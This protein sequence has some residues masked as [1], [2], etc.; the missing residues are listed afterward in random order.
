MHLPFPGRHSVPWF[1]LA[2]RA[3]Q[4]AAR[5]SLLLLALAVLGAA[6]PPGTRGKARPA[7]PARGTLPDSVLLRID[8][9]ED[10]T[11]RRFE[12]AVRLLGGDPDSLTPADRDQFLDMVIEQRLLAARAR[13]DPHPWSPLDSV[14]YRSELD[15]ILLRAALSDRFDDVE[16]RRRAR[17]QPDLDEEAMG[18][19]ARES[20]MVDV[21]PEWDEDLLRLVGSYFAELPK[22]TAEMTI[23]EQ[24]ELANLVPRIPPAETLKVLVRSTLGPLTVADVVGDWR[25]LSSLYRPQVRDAEAVRALAENGIFERWIRRAS[26]DPSL[27]T[28]PV[29]AAVIADRAE[30]HSVSSLLRRELLESIPR[31]S[32]T[33]ERHYRT[34]RS[35]FDLPA[36]ASLVILTLGTERAA[37]SLA[38]LFA[39]PGE[40][41]SLAFRA[42]RSGVRYTLRVTE[43]SDSALYRLATRTGAGGVG[44]PERVEGGWR[45]FKVLALDPRRPQAFAAVR[46]DVERSW[47]EAESERRIRAY[48]DRLKREAKFQRNEAAL[49]ALVRRP[50]GR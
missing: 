45:V 42:Q 44:G 22:P 17:G 24:M 12:R 34:N 48:L 20:L 8:G 16:R 19:A 40:A 25:R 3:L 15:H 2:R 13:R 1:R 37:D 10:I 36:S 43:A 47:N 26:S 11:R 33:L 39:V 5:A 23:R 7:G 41:E 6:A 32:A 28:R 18:M 49:R 27:P 30:Y 9:R 21:K 31:D 14:Q 38:R 35:E 46:G 4:A 50:G 29:V